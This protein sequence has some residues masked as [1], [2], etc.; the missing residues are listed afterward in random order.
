MRANLGIIVVLIYP[1]NPANPIFHLN[2]PEL[3]P[4]LRPQR[5]SG[6]LTKQ[7]NLFLSVTYSALL[8]LLCALRFGFIAH[9]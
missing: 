6:T 9:T 3:M 5:L 8:K 1:E 7:C 2:V 4:K